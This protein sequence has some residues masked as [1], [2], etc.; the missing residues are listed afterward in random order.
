MNDRSRQTPSWPTVFRTQFRIVIAALRGRPAMWAI[1]PFA[2]LA[3]AMAAGDG[4]LGVISESQPDGGETTRSGWIRSADMNLEEGQAAVLIVFI[5]LTVFG[6]FWPHWV[7]R[8]ALPARRDY[9]WAMPV[10]RRVHDATRVLAG[11]VTLLVF[12]FASFAVV[13]SVS[14]ACGHAE[15]VFV[16]WQNWLTGPLL[17]YLVASVPAVCTN[18]PTAW[19]LG[20]L[21]TASGAA[22]LATPLQQ[23][24]MR[25]PMQSLSNLGEIAGGA[26]FGALEDSDVATVSGWTTATCLGG[27]AAAVAIAILLRSKPR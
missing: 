14:A 15:G 26:V 9:H 3:I 10:D 5:G 23:D 16:G 4:L 8:D 12:S 19:I 6:I 21:V 20:V 1:A 17:Y 22:A 11:A 24:W 13:V 2:V 27:A 25:A 7:W 18:R